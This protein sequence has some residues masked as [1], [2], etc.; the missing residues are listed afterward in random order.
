MTKNQASTAEIPELLS[1][2]RDA[3]TRHGKA[4]ETGDHKAANKMAN[5]V[6][7]V[8]SELRRRGAREHLLPLLTD[9]AGGVRL[10]AASHALEFAPQ[11]GAQVL[12]S[13]ASAGRL[14]G[15]S[16]EMT[17]RE[18]RAGRLQFP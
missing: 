5:V 17:L 14:L 1:A 16:A 18:W 4:T 2:Y 7:T 10:W 9:E 11:Q 12:T 13:L 6:A 8:Y 3:A 15:M